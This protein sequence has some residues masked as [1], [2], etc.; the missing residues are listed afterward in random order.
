MTEARAHGDCLEQHFDLLD[1]DM[2]ARKG[3]GLAQGQVRARL[4]RASLPA[5][6]PVARKAMG[7]GDL[8]GA[9]SPAQPVFLSP[10]DQLCTWARPRDLHP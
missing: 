1:Q 2:E 10:R 4:E 7:G 5:M 3:P 9:P 8:L 6:T